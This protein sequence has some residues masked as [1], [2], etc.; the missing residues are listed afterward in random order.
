MLRKTKIVG[1]C[2]PASEDKQTLR[3]LILSGVNVVRNNF[4]HGDH[5]EHIKRFHLV[6]ELNQELGTYVGTMMDTKGPEIR[7][8]HFKEGKALIKQGQTVTVYMDEIIG[9]ETKFSVT[10]ASLFEDVSIGTTLLIDDGYLSLLVIDKNHENR[11]LITVAKNTHLVKNRRGVN[12]P[13][14]VL[15]MPFLSDKDIDDIRFACQHDYDYI[16]ASFT[17]RKEDVF[18]IRDLLQ[19]EGKDYIK[20]IA[21]IENQEGINNLDDIIDAADGIMVARGDLGVEI[22]AEDLPQMQKKMVHQCQQKGKLVIVATQMLESMQQ[23]PRP[24]RAEVSD[25]A[26]AVYDGTDATMLSGEMAQGN[27]P[28]ES[29]EYMAKITEK[30]ENHVDH[31]KFTE[32]ALTEGDHLLDAVSFAAVQAAIHY[33]VKAM[34][35]YGYK[36]TDNLSKYRSIAPI[37]GVVDSYHK[38]TSLSLFYGV[39][40]VIGQEELDRR[41]KSLG[42]VKG[43]TI[44]VVR[45]YHIE[46]INY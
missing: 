32:A 24:T 10:Y 7:T 37:V 11:T 20:I 27:Y 8:H 46:F 17:R 12:V 41:L 16:A 21:K 3:Q 22:F 2:G 30:A 36:A 28:I 13:N 38:A 23:N 4:S 40:P 45:K 1:T 42:V 39:F 9:D 43:D 44:I 5:E 25:V 6:H 26:N 14:T 35:A 29:V 15:N 31:R 18:A 33:R 19:S 34:I